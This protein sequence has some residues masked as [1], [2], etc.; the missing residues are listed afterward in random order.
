MR[1]RSSSRN[2]R[3]PALRK[4]LLAPEPAQPAA[5]SNSELAA[6]HSSSARC[7]ALSAPARALA[8]GPACFGSRLNRSG[9][10]SAVSIFA[11]M[12]LMRAISASAS[13]IRCFGELRF[14]FLLR[15]GFLAAAIVAAVLART[16]A[17]AARRQHH[18]PVIVEIAVEIR[19][20]VIRDHP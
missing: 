16:D 11:I 13:E 2:F 1:E 5:L 8:S 4:A 19:H 20:G 15:L 7:S 10:A 6:S 18:A 12:P 9:S 17:H 14:S 3:F